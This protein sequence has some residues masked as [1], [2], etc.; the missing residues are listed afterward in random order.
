MEDV[1]EEQDEEPLK[2]PEDTMTVRGSI[3]L[4][5][6]DG[7]HGGEERKSRGGSTFIVII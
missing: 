6:G 1:M 7:G 5:D 2:S 4:K 3:R